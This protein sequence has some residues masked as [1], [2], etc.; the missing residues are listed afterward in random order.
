MRMVSPSH[1]TYTRLDEKIRKLEAELAKHRDIIRRTRPGPAQE[2]A[3]RR[4]LTVLKQKRL[5]EN[6]RDQLYNQQ[7]NIEQTTFAVQSM[8][9]SVHTVQAMA[10]RCWLRAALASEKK[11]LR[12]VTF[13]FG[14]L[15]YLMQV[16]GKELKN[17]M[18]HKDLRIENI[19]AMQD[20][21]QDL[22][23]RPFFLVVYREDLVSIC[24]RDRHHV[25]GLNVISL[26]GLAP[27][28]ITPRGLQYCFILRS[29]QDMQNE[30]TEALG[31]NYATPDD[32]DESELMG[33]LDAL[34][35]ELTTETE[36]G[37]GL[38]SY[39]QEPDLP[40]AP[41]AVQPQ[42]QQAGAEDEFGLPAVPAM[43]Q[44]T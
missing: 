21:M 34:E 31:A 9:D 36:T 23:V 17:V 30:I 5:Y 2:A 39:L 16:A 11:D 43:P 42:A 12:S 10:V 7:Y 14:A 4:A 41:T 40:S 19:E 1:T 44:R 26:S 33:E 18:K 22:L 15:F 37:Q 20:N 13:A 8:Q 29:P 38:P 27:R 3:K 25:W 28:G 24:M 32:I 35:D 6:Q